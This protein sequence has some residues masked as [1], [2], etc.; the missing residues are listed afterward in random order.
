MIKPFLYILL[1]SIL[2]LFISCNDCEKFK[3]EVYTEEF[4]PALDTIIV[5]MNSILQRLDEPKMDELNVIE[6]YRLLFMSAFQERKLVR[7]DKK[8]NEYY[9]VYKDFSGDQDSGNIVLKEHIQKNITKD[10]WKYINKLIY[11]SNYWAAK[12]FDEPPPDVLDGYAFT[13]EGRRPQAAKCNKRTEQIVF[14]STPDEEDKMGDL[15][16]QILHYVDKIKQED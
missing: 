13:L 16:F 4:N 1:T 14:R 10:N 11:N 9:L 6:S 7:I 5:E 3:N 8:E 15:C 2:I 12:K